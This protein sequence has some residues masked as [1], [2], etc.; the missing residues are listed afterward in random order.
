M[1]H[2]IAVFKVIWRK[3]WVQF[4]FY[5][6]ELVPYTAEWKH[7]I[8]GR[9]GVYLCDVDCVTNFVIWL[10]SFVDWAWVNN[11]YSY[12]PCHWGL[13]GEGKEQ[14]QEELGL[15]EQSR[16]WWIVQLP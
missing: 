16:C 15:E 4:C 12:K 1:I 5:P 10:Y 7:W 13:V 14:D 11:K 3:E 6:L 8:Y 9:S 2:S